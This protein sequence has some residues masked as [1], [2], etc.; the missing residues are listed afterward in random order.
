M[1]IPVMNREQVALWAPSKI[2]AML[3][4]LDRLN[5]KLVDRFI[6][7]G[8]GHERPS[9][10]WQLDDPLAQEYKRISRSQDVL[11]DEISHRYGPGAPSRL[12]SSF[13]VKTIGRRG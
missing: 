3:D 10:T 5:R 1:V 8:R 4:R 12:P 7:E 11:R 13:R 6:A 2:N 9:E